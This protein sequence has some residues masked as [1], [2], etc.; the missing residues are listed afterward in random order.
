MELI[1]ININSFQ[2]NYLK[3]RLR[4]LELK[5]SK[6]T[7]IKLG[8]PIN[9]WQG[10]NSCTFKANIYHNLTL[11]RVKVIRITFNLSRKSQRTHHG[12]MRCKMLI[13]LS[14]VILYFENHLKSENILFVQTVGFL[15][16][17]PHGLYDYFWPLRF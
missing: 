15:N 16:I 7:R 5:L 1:Y 17:Q 10:N 8:F 2:C 4:N 9:K 3:W 6:L 11:Y 14:N 12:G 13:N